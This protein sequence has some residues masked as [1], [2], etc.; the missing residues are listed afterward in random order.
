[1]T[2]L[3]VAVA[4]FTVLLALSI[5]GAIAEF[6]RDK[7]SPYALLCVGSAIFFAFCSFMAFIFLSWAGSTN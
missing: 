2:G 1:M 6:I 7:R 3:I 5:W 4:L